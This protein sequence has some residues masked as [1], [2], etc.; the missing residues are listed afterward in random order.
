MCVLEHS[1]QAINQASPTE[2]AE[3]CAPSDSKHTSAHAL[4][5]CDYF[6]LLKFPLMFI[7]NAFLFDEKL[8]DEGAGVICPRP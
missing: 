5:F 2:H 8:V 4:A 1:S 7:F 3:W 6:S